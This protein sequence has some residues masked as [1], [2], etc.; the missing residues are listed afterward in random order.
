MLQDG[1]LSTIEYN[2]LIYTSNLFIKL[3]DLIT[4][5]LPTIHKRSVIDILTE[6]YEIKKITRNVLIEICVNL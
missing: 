3:H 5:Y 6:L 2:D 4:V 1:L